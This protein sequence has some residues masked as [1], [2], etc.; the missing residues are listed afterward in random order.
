MHVLNYDVTDLEG[1]E[2][3][4]YDHN[5]MDSGLFVVTEGTTASDSG[6]LVVNKFA[7]IYYD[8]SSNEW[9]ITKGAGGAEVAG[10]EATW[11]NNTGGTLF[12]N[13]SSGRP[14]TGLSC[15]LYTSPSPRD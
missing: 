3:S 2:Q 5:T 15:L 13:D 8:V 7:A 6:N 14:T 11:V 4:S 1:G 12:T 10:D 9:R